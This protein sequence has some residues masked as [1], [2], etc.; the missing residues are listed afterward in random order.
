V[1]IVPEH[2]A[3]A[4][5]VYVPHVDL[6]EEPEIEHLYRTMDEA[7]VSDLRLTQDEMAPVARGEIPEALVGRIDALALGRE[8]GRIGGVR[9]R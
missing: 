2:V 1:N 3:A 8:P 7:H 9:T 4:Q 5:P 6:D